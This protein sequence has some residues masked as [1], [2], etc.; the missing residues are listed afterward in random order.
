VKQFHH[1]VVGDLALSYE[2]MEL[3]GDTGLTLYIH[4]AEPGSSSED[5][6]RLLARWAATLDQAERPAASMAPDGA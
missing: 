2:A 4:T 3:S 6:L 5:R 1:Q